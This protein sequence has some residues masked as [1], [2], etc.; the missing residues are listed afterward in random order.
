MFLFNKKAKSQGSL[1]QTEETQKTPEVVIDHK[2]GI[3]KMK[4]KSILED[5]TKFY[6]PILDKLEWYKDHAPEVTRIT[7]HLDYFNTPASKYLLKIF[8]TFE[9]LYTTNKK[10][11]SVL[12]YYEEGDLD[13]KY[14][15][16]DFRTMLTI[17]FKLVE[18]M[19]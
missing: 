19:E 12:W 2:A 13:M 16:E 4:G 7:V 10:E 17:P 18:V 15:G 1:F 14:C 9:E 8:K 3:I 5:S 11:V 6:Q